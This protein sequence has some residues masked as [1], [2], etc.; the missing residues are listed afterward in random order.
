MELFQMNSK[1]QCQTM[2]SQ[3]I[4]VATSFDLANYGQILNL[5]TAY[6]SATNHYESAHNISVFLFL[7]VS[8]QL[9]NFRLQMILIIIYKIIF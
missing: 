5:I 4:A 8:N 2:F 1:L 3:I 6:N 9:V 7:I